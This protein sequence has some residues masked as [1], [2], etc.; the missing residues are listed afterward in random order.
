MRR[1]RIFLLDAAPP[2][3]TVRASAMRKTLLLGLLAF[4]PFLVRCG[5]DDAAG[6]PAPAP[7]DGV[8]A[9]ALQAAEAGT[10]AATTPDAA[11]AL[12]TKSP[13]CGMAATASPAA[14]VVKTVKVSGVDRTFVLY[15]P[16]GYEPQ[17]GYPVVVLFHGIGATGPDMADYIKMQDYAAGN[18][19]VAFPSAV[20]GQWDTGGDQDLAF[21]D[22]LLGSLETS[23][24]VNEQRVFALGFSFGAYMAN[25][26]GCKRSAV[27]RGFVAADGGFQSASGCGPTAALIYHRTD[28]DD[29][30]VGN[31]QRAR[32]KWLTI[33]GCASTTKP[34]TDFGLG[35][36]GCVQ[37]DGCAASA[38]L[39]WC[40]DTDTSP[41]DYKHD[42]RSV[43]R[44]PIWSWFSHF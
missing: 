38:P 26:L 43:Y 18:A 39:L 41:P 25:H 33:N 44:V 13:G 3:A 10:D 14:G 2:S 24:C 19:I 15:V 30:A 21:F 32:D 16:K 31:G 40:E 42:L 5:G 36:L 23:L 34:V 20:N 27:L 29:E 35:G 4:V 9:S 11:P 6:G 37:Y 12:P 1:T 17:R 22:A 28:D 8:D 7:S